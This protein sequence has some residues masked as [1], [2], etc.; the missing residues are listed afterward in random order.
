M[1]IA[2]TLF[3]AL[4]I[5]IK[6]MD[7]RSSK[8][9]AVNLC[10]FI[11]LQYLLVIHLSFLIFLI[12]QS[13]PLCSSLSFFFLLFIIQVSSIVGRADVLCCIF[14]LISFLAFCR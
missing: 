10:A 4:K 14:F 12:S 13:H 8:K 11:P 7:V 5:K 9:N 3:F 6:V 2:N 1:Y